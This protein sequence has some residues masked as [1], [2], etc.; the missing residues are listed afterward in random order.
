MHSGFLNGVK[1]ARNQVCLTVRDCLHAHLEDA[2]ASAGGA[3]SSWTGV[4]LWIAGHSLGGA[5]ARV[6]VRL[7]VAV[8]MSGS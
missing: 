2:R 6:Y 8:M 4:E 1:L 3:T 7:G 5:Y